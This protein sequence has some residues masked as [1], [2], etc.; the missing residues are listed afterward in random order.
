MGLGWTVDERSCDRA[1][2]ADKSRVDG[3]DGLVRRE[4][5]ILLP[6]VS[7]LKASSDD[8]RFDG[9]LTEKMENATS[10]QAVVHVI[11]ST[12]PA[13]RVLGFVAFSGIVNVTVFLS[14]IWWFESA[15]ST[16]SLCSPGGSP[17]KTIG[18]P[19]D[20]SQCHGSP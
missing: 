8:N 2:S 16:S 20:S 4:S 12:I 1:P 7:V 15:N 19:L 11:A 18:V 17:C 6:A 3:V 10:A 5:N 14:R 13:H 9:R